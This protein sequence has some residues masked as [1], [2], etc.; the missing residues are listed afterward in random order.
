M[1][2]TGT[3]VRNLDEKQRFSVP[4]SIRQSLGDSS[5]S[6]FYLAPGT[7]GSLALYPEASFSA[8]AEQMAQASATGPDVRA[9]SRLF[10]AQA[11]RLEVD[12]Q[13]R[14][15]VPA[16]LAALASLG[17]EIVMIGVRDHLE[18][19]DHSRWEDYLSQEQLRYDEIAD[20]A[21][22]DPTSRTPSHEQAG[23]HKTVTPLRPR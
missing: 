14:L 2:L 7:D 18:L 3:F 5:G 22:D 11:R 21:F 9:F 16:E 10:F 17:K 1:L 23:D 19:W 20:R 12:R 4:R 13:G 15:R 6:V 8:I